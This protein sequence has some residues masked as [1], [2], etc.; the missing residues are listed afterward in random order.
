VIAVL[1]LADEKGE[2]L[3]ADGDWTDLAANIY[4]P[5]STIPLD[6]IVSAAFELSDI[7]PETPDLGQP[8]DSTE[9]FMFKLLRENPTFRFKE[10]Y[11]KHY[12]P[13]SSALDLLLVALSATSD[14]ECLA[15]AERFLKG[16]RPIHS[17]RW[18]GHRGEI[19]NELSA[20]AILHGRTLRGE[21]GARG[22]SAIF[23]AAAQARED[24]GIFTPEDEMLEKT[25]AAL[26]KEATLDI[27]GENWR[28]QGENADP[29]TVAYGLELAGIPIADEY[30]A[31]VGLEYAIPELDL[32]RAL[33]NLTER[34][35]RIFDALLQ[36]EG[37]RKA[38]A[39]ALKMTDA[40]LRVAI[41][42]I[43]KKILPPE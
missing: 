4:V 24:S 29:Q 30:R 19:L 9:R 8:K 23:P 27:L 6:R 34:E 42:R 32:E 7:V 13:G 39:K 36:N 25:K 12:R 31:A 16:R 17:E 40:Y 28:P 18:R 21:M 38:T 2:R 14:D 33:S 35:K 26:N 3:F 5:K 15:A 37:D 41:H 11:R 20:T 1:V 43:K 22:L 10:H